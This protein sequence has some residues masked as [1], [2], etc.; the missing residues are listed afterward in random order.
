MKIW[1]QY[2]F[3]FSLLIIILITGSYI[4]YK[5]FIDEIHSCTSNPLIYASQKFEREYGN[6]L[7][8]TAYFYDA[9]NNFFRLEFNSTAGVIYDADYVEEGKPFEYIELDLEKWSKYV[10]NS[11]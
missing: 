7:E 1:L 11:S 5:I 6:A 10:V 3:L 8:G 2:V 4:S 9:N